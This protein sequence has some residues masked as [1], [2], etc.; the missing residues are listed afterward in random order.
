MKFFLIPYSSLKSSYFHIHTSNHIT[1]H[2]SSQEEEKP[3]LRVSGSI[4]GIFPEYNGN[5]PY[6]ICKLGNI[7][8]INGVANRKGFLSQPV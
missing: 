5:I 2:I 7:F 3:L 8:I 4:L 1:N 6:H